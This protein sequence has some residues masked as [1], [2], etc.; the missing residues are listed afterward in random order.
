M[1]FSVDE[2]FVQR[3]SWELISLL[4][5]AYLLVRLALE[6]TYAG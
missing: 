5:G 4:A 2:Q 1:T 3:S 6:G